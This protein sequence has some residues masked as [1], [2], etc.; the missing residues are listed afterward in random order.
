MAGPPPGYQRPTERLGGSGRG[1]IAVAVTAAVF[2]FLVV[3]KPWE[4][5]GVVPVPT[6]GP[7]AQA[8]AHRTAAAGATAKR[9]TEPTRPPWPAEAAAIPSETI[10]AASGNRLGI[11]RRHAGAWGVW[12]AGA[13]PRLIR[14]ES[15]TGWVAVSP[16]PAQRRHLRTWR[17]GRVRTSAIVSRSW[18]DGP[19]SSRSPRHARCPG[20][21]LGFTGGGRT[22][23]ASPRWPGP[24]V[25]GP[26]CP[27][28]PAAGLGRPA[29]GPDRRRDVADREVRTPCRGR[30]TTTAVTFCL[31]PSG[32]SLRREP[33][34]PPATRPLA[35]AT[36]HRVASITGAPMSQTLRTLGAGAL[37]ALIVAVAALSVRTGPVVG[38]PTDTSTPARTIT[39][40]ATGN[41][42]V[43]PD[44]ARVN[45]GRRPPSPRSRRPGTAPRSR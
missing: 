23:R 45:L 10:E 21:T 38:A 31:R 16:E 44:V 43:V 17:P 28:A 24:S 39:V 36:P 7:Q 40:S 20:P 27:A 33:S 2:L 5:A 15:W 13:G 42:T 32:R 4:S 29:P 3:L 26:W 30:G 25:P 14:E 41:I 34:P 12:T 35:G 9:P 11:S 37:G 1:P 6:A 22:A 18:A 19:R 8:E